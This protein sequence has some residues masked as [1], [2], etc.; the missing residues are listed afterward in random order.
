MAS[1]I[2]QWAAVKSLNETGL[3]TVSFGNGLWRVEQIACNFIKAGLMRHLLPQQWSPVEMAGD[4]CH[5]ATAASNSHGR[6]QCG[7]K[8][9]AARVSMPF[10]FA[11]CNDSQGNWFY[12]QCNCHSIRKQI[13][14]RLPSLI[15][16]A[17]TGVNFR[18]DQPVS[19][20]SSEKSSFCLEEKSL[21]LDSLH[22]NC[23]VG[24][25]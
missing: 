25:N 24:L 18:H 19:L 6:P 5:S 13:N 2:S 12:N 16:I 20:L 3:I 14:E 23:L 10:V 17:V 8:G 15:A 21:Y 11:L 1:F 4:I 9:V 7:V 22:T